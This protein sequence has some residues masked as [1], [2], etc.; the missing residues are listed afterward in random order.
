MIVESTC[1]GKLQRIMSRTV[2]LPDNTATTLFTVPLASG[3]QTCG[4]LNV[5]LTVTDG[6]THQASTHQ[7]NFAAVDVATVLTSTVTAD[8]DNVAQ[9]LPA[10]ST[11]STNI[12]IVDG[13]GLIE[14]QFLANSSLVSPTITC[15]FILELSHSTAGVVVTCP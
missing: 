11:L 8:G 10:A 5:F 2:T 4:I 6:V 7:C 3:A 1:G 12:S 15:R 9:A 13:A 14:V